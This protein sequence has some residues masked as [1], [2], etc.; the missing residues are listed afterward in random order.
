MN[1]MKRVLAAVAL[2][3]AALTMTGTA[4]AAEPRDE[5]SSFLYPSHDRAGWTLAD[6][7]VSARDYVPAEDF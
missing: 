4:Q 7:M 2:A 5:I 1:N 3:G 6:G